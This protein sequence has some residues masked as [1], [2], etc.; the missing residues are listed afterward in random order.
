MLSRGFAESGNPAETQ[1]TIL[2]VDDENETLNLHTRM[3]QT[4][5]PNSQIIQAHN[6]R[7]ALQAVR[8]RRPDLILLDLMMPEIDGFT[9]LETMQQDEVSRN[10]PVIVLT[11]QALTSADMERLNCGVTSVLGKGMYSVQE[12]MK[13]VTD[14]L[15]RRRRAG[16]ETQ[17]V[18]LKAMAYLHTNYSASITRKDVADYVGLSERHLT[19]CFNQELGLTPMTYL[20]RYRVK[21]AKELLKTGRKSIAEIAEIVGF[22]SG[23]YFTRVFRDEVGLSPR[24]FMRSKGDTA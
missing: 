24:D 19:R 6:G 14:A 18:V 5:Y 13:H 11:G 3:V 12:T 21:Q 15:I 22:S 9:V 8:Q 10:I 7:E 17:R 20:N 23:G 4:Q 16:S 1:K 2:I